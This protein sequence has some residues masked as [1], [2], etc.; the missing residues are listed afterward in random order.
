MGSLFPCVPRTNMNRDFVLFHFLCV[1]SSVLNGLAH[2]LPGHVLP[3]DLTSACALTLRGVGA[4]RR[5]QGGRPRCSG[6]AGLTHFLGAG[7]YGGSW[8]LR[9]E[10]PDGTTD[11]VISLLSCLRFYLTCLRKPLGAYIVRVVTPSW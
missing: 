2:H 3:R 6:H 10:S 7:C 11:F 9:E 4:G 5:G 1:C 8:R